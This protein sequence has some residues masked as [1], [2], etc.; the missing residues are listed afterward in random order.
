M[1][2]HLGRFSAY[3]SII[4]I[5]FLFYILYTCIFVSI[6]VCIICLSLSGSILIKDLF[7]RQG[8]SR[9]IY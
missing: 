5:I 8:L 9:R 4:Y 1:S 3:I 7:S 2:Y 6:E